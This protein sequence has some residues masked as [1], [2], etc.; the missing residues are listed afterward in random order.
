LF[1]HIT[2]TQRDVIHKNIPLAPHLPHSQI[3][4]LVTPFCSQNWKVPRREISENMKPQPT[5][6]KGTEQQP[7]KC[8]RGAR[9]RTTGIN[10]VIS[11]EK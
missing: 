11:E 7:K 4:H 6:D 3:Y 5:F 8:P 1:I 9:R 10:V 2:E